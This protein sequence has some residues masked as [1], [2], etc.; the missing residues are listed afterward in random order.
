[1]L[2]ISGVSGAS[3]TG[4]RVPKWTGPCCHSKVSVFP[5]VTGRQICP[6]RLRSKCAVT[7]N[8]RLFPLA[9]AS[10]AHEYALF[11]PF[12]SRASGTFVHPATLSTVSPWKPATVSR[13][14]PVV[15]EPLLVTLAVSSVFPL[16]L[17]TEILS[18]SSVV[19]R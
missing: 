4:L 9:N 15:V 10:I 16:R 11:E 6:C 17:S 12:G 3:D 1:M 14:A 2:S 5:K 19:I 13:T 8:V 7:S 18:G